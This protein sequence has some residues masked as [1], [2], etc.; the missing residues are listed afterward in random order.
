VA[1]INER[2]HPEEARHLAR[3]IEQGHFSEARRLP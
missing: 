1:G 3:L 2:Y